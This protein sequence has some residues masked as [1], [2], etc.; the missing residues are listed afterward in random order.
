RPG[1]VETADS[2]PLSGPRSLKVIVNESKDWRTHEGTPNE[3][4]QGDAGISI[5]V[6]TLV[7]AEYL[8]VG[9]D[10]LVDFTCANTPVVDGTAHL[11]KAGVLQEL[12]TDYTIVLATGV[13]SFLVAPAVGQHI[14]VRYY[15]GTTATTNWAIGLRPVPDSDGVDELY[16]AGWG[17]PAATD[18]TVAGD[19]SAPPWPEPYHEIL[20]WGLCVRAAIRDQDRG[21][22][23][24]AAMTYFQTEYQSMLGELRD[25]S[26]RGVDPIPVVR[27]EGASAPVG[28]YDTELEAY[29]PRVL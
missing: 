29:V 21:K 26:L 14:T 8:G 19:A 28:T 11:Y 16:L 17:L 1:G 15:H 22:G 18:I 10:I 27:G 2:G 23:N 24:K 6:G 20:T 13:I 4:Y 3:W 5:T 9:N 25:V 12:V 7:E